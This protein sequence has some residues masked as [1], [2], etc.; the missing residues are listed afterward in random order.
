MIRRS[1]KE[2]QFMLGNTKENGLGICF[3][4]ASKS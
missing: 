3:I 4:A 2:K 1:I